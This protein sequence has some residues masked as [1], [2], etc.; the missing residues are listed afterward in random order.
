[1]IWADG[2][3]TTAPTARR[4][5]R[6]IGRMQHPPMNVKEVKTV[7]LHRHMVLTGEKIQAPRRSKEFVQ[8]MA[9]VGMF[10]LYV[11]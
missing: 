3:W 7:L 5:L 10:R 9:K 1:M 2:H 8:L 6:E 4:L 11:A